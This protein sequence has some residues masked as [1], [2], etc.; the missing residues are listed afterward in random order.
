MSEL[1]KYWASGTV[2]Q[3][4]M[5]DWNVGDAGIQVNSPC[6]SGSVFS[7]EAQHDVQRGQDEHRQ[8]RQRG[9]PEEPVARGV[10]NHGRS[11]G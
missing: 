9:V 4:S 7:D 10:M 3:M 2:C 11:S 5:K 6:T 8:Q 1:T